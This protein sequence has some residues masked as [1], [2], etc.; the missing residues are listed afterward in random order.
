MLYVVTVADGAA[1]PD[2]MILEE[3]QM[4]RAVARVQRTTGFDIRYS[5]RYTAFRLDQ[6]LISFQT[7]I[8]GREITIEKVE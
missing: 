1:R 8:N 7:R 2:V 4:Y 3:G 5:R 6:A